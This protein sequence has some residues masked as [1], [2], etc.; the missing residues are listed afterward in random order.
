MHIRDPTA[1]DWH[2]S[3]V[4][5]SAPLHAQVFALCTHATR[6]RSR[7]WKSCCCCCCCCCR[8]RSWCCCGQ[9]R[10]RQQPPRHRPPRHQPFLGHAVRHAL[11]F[12][13]RDRLH[14][15]HVL[16]DRQHGHDRLDPAQVLHP[17]QEGQ[18]RLHPVPHPSAVVQ[19]GRPRLTAMRQPRSPPTGQ[20]RCGRSCHGGTAVD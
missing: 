19:Q 13:G 5:F 18:P 16:P 1:T 4:G 10:R 11:L 12:H 15:D 20:H 2:T 8:C 6:K 14:R 9:H 3:F 17:I 7:R